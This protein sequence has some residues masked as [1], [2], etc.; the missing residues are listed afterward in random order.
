G[1]SQSYD[2][3]TAVSVAVSTKSAS[4]TVTVTTTPS[5]GA[6]YSQNANSVTTKPLPS[7]VLSHCFGNT[8]NCSAGDA[9]AKCAM[10][11]CG[12]LSELNNPSYMGMFFKASPGRDDFG[13][14]VYYSAPTD[15]WYS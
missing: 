8:S 1:N 4:G 9:I 3:V 13:N 14:P 12:N 7:D 11:D 6:A 5:S 10:T 15:P 2:R